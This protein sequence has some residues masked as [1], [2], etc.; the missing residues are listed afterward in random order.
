MEMRGRAPLAANPPRMQR[1]ER[2]FPPVGRISNKL[3][4]Q[5]SATKVEKPRSN[6]IAFETPMLRLEVRFLHKIIN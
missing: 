5:L 2:K 6:K 1:L 3:K 4:S